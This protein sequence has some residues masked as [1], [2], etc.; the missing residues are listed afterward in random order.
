MHCRWAMMGVAGAA[1]AEVIT[2]VTWTEA[3]VQDSQS[4]LGNGIP[5]SLP[6]IAAIEIFV[7]AFVETKR[8]AETDPVKVRKLACAQLFCF[9][10]CVS[11]V[12]RRKKIINIKNHQPQP[13]PTPVADISPPFP[14]PHYSA[15][16]PAASSTPRAS[17]RVPTSSS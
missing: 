2:G 13:Q 1:G 14:P 4:Y 3:P 11:H 12:D 5:F 9:L 16:T 8:N 10:P 17:P 6:L 15:C 7:M